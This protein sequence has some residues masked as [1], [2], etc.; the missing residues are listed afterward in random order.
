MKFSGLK[1]TKF[2]YIKKKHPYGSQLIDIVLREIFDWNIYIRAMRWS[3]IVNGLRKLNKDEYS[4]LPVSGIIRKQRKTI[5]S[6]MN[7]YF[8]QINK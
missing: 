1:I 3:Y 5:E 4:G 6:T 2:L 7:I 8:W